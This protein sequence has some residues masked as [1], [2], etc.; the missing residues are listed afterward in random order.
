MDISNGIHIVIIYN[1]KG[2]FAMPEAGFISA[3]MIL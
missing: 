1:K 3:Y 2:N